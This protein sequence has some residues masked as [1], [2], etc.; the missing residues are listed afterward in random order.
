MP[1]FYLSFLAVLLAGIAGR[2]QQTVAGLALRQ[3]ARPGVLIVGLGVVALTSF[4]AGWGAT[5]I[6]AELPPP[7][8][9]I[10]AA[11]A[12]G[13][14]GL[15]SLAIA[16][17]RVPREPTLSLGALGFVLLFRQLT[18]APRFL[19]VGMGVAMAA[20]E[21][22]A[23]GGLFSGA[24]LIAIAWGAPQVVTHRAALW[25]RRGAGGVLLL[26]AV[27]MVLSGLGIL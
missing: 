20:P 7:G 4:L 3:G 2:D 23:F 15:E 24:L 18:D 5:V 27:L 12:L 9:N 22:A 1:A 8:R 16:P 26:V 19:M 13:L 14:A 6:L 11:M 25:A 10:F 17:R 21:G